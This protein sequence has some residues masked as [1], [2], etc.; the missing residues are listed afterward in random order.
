M[1][2][3]E[4][5]QFG[6]LEPEDFDR[7][8]VWIGCHTADYGKPWYESTDEET[9]RPWTGKLPADHS[10][11]MLLVKANFELM[12]GSRYSGF[13]TPSDKSDDLGI[14]QPQM[15][16]GEQRFSFWGG[17]FGI[18]GDSQQALY[19]VLNK[20]PRDIFPLEFGAS[21]GLATG[22]VTGQV[23]GFYKGDGVELPDRKF[24]DSS[25][26]PKWFRIQGRGN[27]GYPQPL[28][29]H[30]FKELNY[31]EVCMR[32][33][34]HSGQ[35]APFRFNKSDRREFA[36]F[37]QPDVLFDCFFVSA[38]RPAEI[39]K[40]GILGVTFGPV[41]DHGTG[42]ELSDRVQLQITKVVSCVEISHLP[43]VTCRPNNEEVTAIRERWPSPSKSEK[44]KTSKPGWWGDT[45]ESY[46][47][48]RKKVRKEGEKLKAL[49]Y[50]GRA[51]Y[52]APTSLALLPNSLDNAPDLCQSAEWFGTG[53]LAYRL[54][55]ASERFV[56]LVRER[57]WKGLVFSE[58]PQQGFSERR[59]LKL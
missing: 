23:A 59:E 45:V 41:L 35:H 30:K 19:E 14:Q 56:A 27:R 38:D 25:T 58:V 12:D 32:C 21:P 8:P 7:H 4:L 40:A 24:L 16:V 47:N 2:R 46:F 54:T 6:E 34:L 5:K 20:A 22:V 36:G 9:F 11:G 55:F 48:W 37:W 3:P 52:H 13:V 49:P 10:Q 18:P 26:G 57:K 1:A 43:T 50:C 44:D 33:G 31:L 51:K 53:A 29:K 15:F 42:T 17:M 28:S 39:R